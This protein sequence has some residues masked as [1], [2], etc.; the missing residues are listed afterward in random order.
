MPRKLRDATL[1]S[2]SAR[3]RLSPNAKPHW[4]LIE[5]GLHLGYRRLL[6]GP[7]TWVVRR[8]VGGG[9]YATRNLTTEHDRPIC[10]DDYGDADG[11]AV[12]TFAQAQAKARELRPSS[13]DEAHGAPYTVSAA[14]R[15]YIG[16]LESR[17]KSTLNARSHQRAFIDPALGKDEVVKLT[18]N[19]IR[20]WRDDLAK[21]PPRSRTRPGAKQRYRLYVADDEAARRRQASVNRIYT[22][23]K[24]SLN[25]AFREGKVPSD[26]AWRRVEPF[27]NV[28]ASRLR[29]LRGHEARRLVNACPADFRELVKAALLSGARYGQII[30]LTA[31]DFDEDAG[32]VR[33]ISR[34]GRGKAHQYAATLTLEG[35]EFFKR[36]C[37]GLRASDLIFRRADG[38]PWQ[39]S[40]Q[41]RLM[42]DACKAA[43]LDPPIGFH[44][45]RHTWASLAV[46]RGVPLLIVARNLGHTDTRMC[47]RHYAHLAQSHVADIIRANAP[48]FGFESERV[49]VAMR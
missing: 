40:H 23:L 26:I 36:A 13:S 29:Y 4:R 5:P 37:A 32:T 49:V 1:E 41:I 17:R 2:R 19:R 35:V 12:L 20:K 33:L 43:K 46:M 16:W 27:E 44:G 11:A 21:A 14:M 30:N 47:E 10:A 7:G 28:T 22:T 39:A 6:R 18:A 8:Y 34:K 24:A 25:R 45:L 3:L 31:G 9:G 15:D 42:V 48:Q 38:K